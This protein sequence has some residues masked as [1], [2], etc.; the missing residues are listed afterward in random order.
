MPTVEE[1][2]A[3]A[4]ELIGKVSPEKATE[5]KRWIN[6]QYASG[7]AQRPTSSVAD[8][9]RKTG[10]AAIEEVDQTLPEREPE[11]EQQAETQKQL[12]L[13]EF[14]REG[15]PK[16]A[17]QTPGAQLARQTLQQQM[18]VDPATAMRQEA[19]LLRASSAED[20]QLF[21]LKNLS[22]DP[23][24]F[25]PPEHW[26]EQA[27]FQPGIKDALP[28][29]GH[30]VWEEPSIQMFRRDMADTLMKAGLDPE[31]VDETDPL[32]HRYADAMW[33]Q[34]YRRAAE[35]G[36]SVVRKSMLKGSG[37][38]G[39]DA[40]GDEFDAYGMA[41]MDAI[42]AVT[43]FG[44]GLDL[45]RTGGVATEVLNTLAAGPGG[46]SR[47][48]YNFPGL[49]PGEAPDPAQMQQVVTDQRNM[50]ETGWGQ[51]GQVAGLMTPGGIAGRLASGIGKLL[52]AGGAV[53]NI[54]RGAGIG[55][56]G[57]AGVEG[58]Q[59]T[60]QNLGDVSRGNAP[61]V[62][63]E[64]MGSNALGAGALGL[65]LGAGF[66]ALGEAARAG[67][68]KLLKSS[69]GK[70]VANMEEA[71]I[72]PG[73]FTRSE[74]AAVKAARQRTADAGLGGDVKSMASR[75]LGQPL[76]RAWRDVDE[77]GAKGEL[78][79]LQHQV[80]EYL[81]SPDG[82][83]KVPINNTADAVLE[84]MESRVDDVGEELPFMLNMQG[85]QRVR[86][87]LFEKPR[88]V[89][90]SEAQKMAEGGWRQIP[91]EAPRGMVAVSRVRQLDA[92][93]LLEV[94]EAIDKLA[95]FSGKELTG[96]KEK[97]YRLF[98]RAIRRDRDRFPA[99]RWT[100]GEGGGQLQLTTADGE[101]VSGFSALMG[102]LSEAKRG[103]TKLLDE[104][105][106]TKGSPGL[107][108]TVTEQSQLPTSV[109]KLRR[110]EK[111]AA[112]LED[113][114]VPDLYNPTGTSPRSEARRAVERRHRKHIEEEVRP[115]LERIP[116]E[117]GSIEM[118]TLGF[119]K[120]IRMVQRGMSPEEAT[121]RYYDPKKTDLTPH[122]FT[123]RLSSAA[124]HI[125]GALAKAPKATHVPVVFRG[126]TLNDFQVNRMLE[127]GTFNNGGMV[128]SFSR[129]PLTASTFGPGTGHRVL[130]KVKHKNGV[131]IETMSQIPQEQEVLLPGTSS[132]K[133][134]DA[135]RMAKGPG[136][137]TIV[138]E[139]EELG[140]STL[141]KGARARSAVKEKLEVE[142]T[143]AQSKQLD[144]LV[145]GFR[146]SEGTARG[147]D[148][149]KELAR[150]AGVEEELKMWA[151][152]LSANRVASGREGVGIG[153]GGIRGWLAGSPAQ[154]A[155][156]STKTLNRL[157][158][159][160]IAQAPSTELRAL[161]RRL[162]GRGGP[163]GPPAF[164]L[165]GMGSGGPPVA[166][167]FADQERDSEGLDPAL[168]AAVMGKEHLRDQGPPLSVEEAGLL[169]QLAEAFGRGMG[170]AMPMP[171]PQQPPAPQAP[172]E[173]YPQ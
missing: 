114:D 88:M 110:V 173:E 128:T 37:S 85:F 45:G 108:S 97:A 91:A 57:A 56:L 87:K 92:R 118:F 170:Q 5:L 10:A 1:K 34:R 79:R 120:P 135:Y 20:Q 23:T 38:P 119:D 104:A 70:D 142:P 169:Q 3:K 107:K 82:A 109:D 139:A 35:K 145:Q 150:L 6:A 126:M 51:A 60:V 61:T 22:K 7:A 144:K 103:S 73:I 65:G 41:A 154:L 49:I 39:S 111:Q 67:K 4:Q 64:Q 31:K 102:R 2:I 26:S 28:G 168:R 8:P 99:N 131:G 143:E 46:M 133:I 32:F 81:R 105:G 122:E 77:L 54:A 149:A 132:F 130:L 59:D 155:V 95:G 90:P 76:A 62:S 84:L 140:K 146:Q 24:L 147:D 166:S 151:G 52:P 43:K 17:W 42:N 152:I 50:R 137:G 74:S 83:T 75:E 30:E 164:A 165:M 27:R 13:Q 44:Y 19:E 9:T 125:E 117:T 101:T 148:A 94:E 15:Q 167:A 33:A 158:A 66:S 138:I 171:A 127:E 157:G 36:E 16:V 40:A 29:V 71:G 124:A 134:T 136:S 58:I 141:G 80:D 18:G 100:R 53:A 86:D 68:N 153:G 98:A 11:P 129:N 161:L 123:K 96:P 78:P 69:L 93:E 115:T 89:T 48:G 25:V 159:E 55:G 162:R 112:D 12:Q 21:K 121:R 160:P 156:R 163:S 106:L 14:V 172:I 63:L 113:L 116:D 72:E 47:E